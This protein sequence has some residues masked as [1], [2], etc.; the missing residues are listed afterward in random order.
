MPRREDIIKQEA[1]ALWRELHGEPVPDIG[2]SELLDQICR[3]LGVAEYDRVQSPFLRS[4]MITRP[5][6]WRERQGRG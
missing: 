6:D 3:N 1:Q 2:G 5:E 4:S